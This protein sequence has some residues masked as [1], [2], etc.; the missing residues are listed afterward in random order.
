[1]QNMSCLDSNQQ[2]NSRFFIGVNNNQHTDVTLPHLFLSRSEAVVP[3]ASQ[4][5]PG[6]PEEEKRRQG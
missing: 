3:A 1:M 6:I 5:E 2:V 4:E